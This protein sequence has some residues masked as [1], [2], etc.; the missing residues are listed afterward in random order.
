MLNG[1]AAA[2]KETTENLIEKY[3]ADFSRTSYTSWGRPLFGYARDDDPLFARLK[4]IVRPTHEL[5]LK[6]PGRQL[7]TFFL[8]RKKSLRAMKKAVTAR[9]CGGEPI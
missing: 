9:S 4:E 8:S 2:L 6:K 7:L 1:G 5:F 3:I